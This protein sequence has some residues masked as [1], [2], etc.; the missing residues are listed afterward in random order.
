[1]PAASRAPLS[2]TTPA[3]SLAAVV[4]SLG[5]ACGPAAPGV[6]RIGVDVHARTL[7]PRLM[8]DTTAYR[9]VNLVYDGLVQQELEEIRSPVANG[10]MI[11]THLTRTLVQPGDYGYMVG[12]LS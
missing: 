10:I 8:R 1:M 12:D 5:L 3:L 7:D 6:V 9:V 4:L 2:P 11:L